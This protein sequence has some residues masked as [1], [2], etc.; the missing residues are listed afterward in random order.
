MDVSRSS[1]QRHAPYRKPEF[2][3]AFMRTFSNVHNEPHT[4]AAP[5]SSELSGIERNTR[6]GTGI[7]GT[8]ESVTTVGTHSI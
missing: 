2:S 7:A 3:K 6:V 4:L 5:R 1:Y 8:S